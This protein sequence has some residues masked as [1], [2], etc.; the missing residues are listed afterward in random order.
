MQKSWIEKFFWLWLFFQ[1]GVGS[2]FVLSARKYFFEKSWS[3][4]KLRKF[5]FKAK[6][7]GVAEKGEIETDVRKVFGQYKEMKIYIIPFWSDEYPRLLKEISDPPAFLFCKG[8]REILASSKLAIVGT[9]SVSN[10]GRTV[11]S[12][13]VEPL[14]DS[15]ITI[16]SGLAQGIDGLVHRNVVK[17]GGSALAVIP[18]GPLKGFPRRNQDLYEKICEENSRGLVISEYYPGVSI[19]RGMFASRNRIVAGLCEL[20]LVIEAP[21]RS[22]ALI[23]AD[24]ALQYNREVAALPGSIFNRASVGTNELI[25]QGAYLVKDGWDVLDLLG[26]D[27]LDEA[28]GDMGNSQKGQPQKENNENGIKFKNGIKLR[29]SFEK[30]FNQNLTQKFGIND[31]EINRLSQTLIDSGISIDDLARKLEATSGE[32]RIFLTKMD[33]KGI[34]RLGDDGLVKFDK[35]C[36]EISHS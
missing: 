11:I 31:V 8:N 22:G 36:C 9:R 2:Q 20:V 19:N 28:A 1:D 29:S 30:I 34:L 21:Q 3:F 7:L 27:Y 4:A 26:S 5:I 23:T 16:V 17:N 32:T 12:Q 18:G 15:Q 24:L 33:L 35:K 6:K 13:M 25:K 10:Y 14:V